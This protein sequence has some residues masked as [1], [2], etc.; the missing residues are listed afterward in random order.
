MQNSKTQ[1][2]KPRSESE[3]QDLGLI[4]ITSFAAFVLGIVLL[5]P[6]GLDGMTDEKTAGDR[7][8]AVDL[9]K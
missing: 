9:G 4:L 2:L 5:L 3:R 8:Y 1:W 6:S 7:A